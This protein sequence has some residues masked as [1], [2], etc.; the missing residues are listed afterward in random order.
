MNRA[1]KYTLLAIVLLPVIHL[2]AEGDSPATEKYQTGRASVILRDS[3]RG[4]RKIQIYI[5]Y[6]IGNSKADSATGTAT[7]SKFPLVCFGHGFVLKAE[8]YTM[9]I[10]RIVSEG[11]IVLFP[12]SESGF[13]PSHKALALDLKFV[14]DESSA[15][16]ADKASPLYGIADTSR[17]LIGHSMGGGAAFL[18]AA[19][20]AGIDAIAAITPYDTK[21]SA[22]EAAAR[23]TIPALIISGSED[24]ITPSHKHQL[25]IYNGLASSQKTLLTINGGTHCP[26]G[27]EKSRCV[28]GEKISGCSNKLPHTRQLE[29]LA[30]YLIP[31]LKYTLMGDTESADAFDS[32]LSTDKEVSYKRTAPLLQE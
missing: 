14:L 11:F 27:A 26:L 8:N 1:I 6:P 10:D 2:T 23:I 20:G 18:A 22:S 21:P 16:A 12:G 3:S 7:V 31:W 29:I 4:L 28:R 25:P 5:Y 19:D 13:F 24:C 30:A 15:M 32:K 17:C 9:L